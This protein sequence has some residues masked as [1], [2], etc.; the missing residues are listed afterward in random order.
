MQFFDHMTLG[1]NA[2]IANAREMANGNLLVNARAAR[3][4]NIQDYLGAEVGRPD[5]GV[6]RIYRDADEVF[7]AESLK[8][9]GHKPVTLDHPPAPVTPDTWGG[10]AR[11]HVGDEVVRDG[12]F[13]RI[14]MMLADR[15]AI[16]DVKSGRR[17]EIS[18]GYV[19]SLDWTPG[20]TP[21]G[22]P[23]DARQTRIVVD[24]VAI[25]AR[26]RAGPDCRIGDE[27]P[28]DGKTMRALSDQLTP[29]QPQQ[30]KPAPMSERTV[31]IGDHSVTVSDAAAIAISDLQRQNQTLVA[32][33]LQLTADLNAART[34]HTTATTARDAEIAG[35]RREVEAKDGEIAV[36]KQQ[37]ADAQ[38]TPAKLDAA[39]AARTAVLS[40]AKA[41]LGDAYN[42]AG[43]TEAQIRRDAVALRMGDAATTMSYAAIDGAFAALTAIAPASDPIRN[44]FTAGI[45]TG[46]A[47]SPEAR[48]AAAQAKRIAD[49]R[50]AYKSPAAA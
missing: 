10:V 15:A 21:D 30:R 41:V 7:R 42:G 27:R 22:R 19:C 45:Q 48:A 13:V 9:F 38:M 40:A 49:M 11:G 14:P 25:V 17:R 29:P 2:E 8:T 20:T 5:L 36:L 6:V 32:D 46:D 26:G 34:G 28:A 18:A 3:G 31:I 35:V 37:L 43:K 47:A 24:H 44:A 23:Y 12:E 1:A 16:D 33:N 39:V 4:G 50:N